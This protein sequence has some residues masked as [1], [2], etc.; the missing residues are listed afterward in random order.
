MGELKSLNILPKTRKEQYKRYTITV[1]YDPHEKTWHWFF[2]IVTATPVSGTASTLE[3]A[4]HA[5]RRRIDEL[6][7]VR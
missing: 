4:F 5:A 1:T 3:R 6:G 7:G 2:A